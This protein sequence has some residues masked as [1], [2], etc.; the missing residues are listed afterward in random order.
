MS[1]LVGR[2][3]G[4]YEVVSLLGVGGMGEVYRARDT[5]LERD[6]AVK[7]LPDAASGDP[8]WLERF[9]RE[10]RALSRLSHPNILEIF[11]AG[12]DDGIRYVVTELVEGRTLRDHL[13]HGRLQIRKAVAIADAI[14]RGLG[15]AHAQGV[16]HRDVKPENVMLT[17]DGRVKVL[18]FGIASLHEPEPA[19]IDAT[20]AQTVTSAG[21][22]LGTIGYM[23]PEQVRGETADA[24]S[25][26]FAV[27]C[28]LYEMLTGRRA[29]ERATPA[30][31]LAAIM[32]EEPEPLGALV[33]DLPSSL[34]RVVMRCLEKEPG[35]RFQSAADIAFALRAAE[36]SRGH[37]PIARRRK[38]DRR[39][40][41]AAIVGA[42]VVIA[43][44]L[45]WRNVA[46]GPPSLPDVLHL[47][48]MP[49][50]AAGGAEED[51]LAAAGLSEKLIGDLT[52]IEE[53]TQGA[54]WVLP[55][56]GR[57]R[58]DPVGMRSLALKYGLTATVT[59]ELENGSDRMRLELEVVDPTSGHRLRHAV[60][61]D[62]V[63]NLNTL[64]VTA[65][66]LVAD[67]LGQD[68]AA[69]LRERLTS[70]ST[71]VADALNGYLVG[72]G[73][74]AAVNGKTGSEIANLE[75]AA[76][77]FRAAA[78]ADPAFVS[79]R[80][81]LARASAML[82]AQTH[83]TAWL[84]TGLAEIEAVGR[85]GAPPGEAS[86][87]EAELFSSA[88]R[89]EEAA[90]SLETAVR[91]RPASAE[92]H[93]ELGRMYQ[94]L[95]RPDDAEAELER[96]VYL[97]PGY[98]I[99]HHW[100]ARLYLSTGAYESAAVQF[101]RVIDCAP[102]Y[103]GGYNNLGYVYHKVGR[104]EAARDVFEQSLAI[105]PQNNYNAVLN[106][107]TLYFE[108]SRFG[109]AARMFEQAVAIDETNFMSWGNLA[110]SYQSSGRDADRARECFE[111]AIEVAEA[112][113]QRSPGD[114]GLLATLATY[115]AA[116]GRRDE[117][118]VAAEQAI[119][120]NPTDPQAIAG[121]ADALEDLGDRDRALEW[122]EK[123]FAAG[124][125]PSRFESR[126]SW[127]DLVANPRYRALKQGR[128]HG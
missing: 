128:S 119:A 57:S 71:N 92:L 37:R 12:S 29:F 88:G 20:E 50:S 127:R 45:A 32:H 4:R 94:R 74:L 17:S 87:V 69:N 108:A 23:A 102:R 80:L 105:Q 51:R 25:D 106:L 8:A 77:S 35:E 67:L 125:P 40:V 31:T 52:L 11:D 73:R 15:A 99:T 59:G 2:L 82:L 41:V 84:E 93:Q 75:A 63:A 86:A 3:L 36:G 61:Q 111:R 21:T 1:G 16:V 42:A 123:A 22:L 115:L 95:G 48:V 122:V 79:A 5:E 13:E 54:V 64:Q 47:A 90:V 28:V 103:E 24:R 65:P 56:R 10:A 100:L 30:A 89:F 118:L 101:R 107:G 97:R 70:S 62:G 6:V 19:A 116:V 120:A 68:N 53:V 60:S 38:L 91:E 58:H 18:D 85:L 72:L 9:R 46:F 124:V 98:W 26:V 49:F 104:L 109:D 83:D 55:N 81:G 27:G 110:F 114:A 44:G 39:L 76:D 14:A 66:I 34:A 33:P 112:E 126:P 7:V 117:G 43:A 113:R 121:I 96:A 78:R